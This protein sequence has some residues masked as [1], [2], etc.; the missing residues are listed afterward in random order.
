[1]TPSMT[2]WTIIA[3]GLVTGFA[4]IS[5][6]VLSDFSRH[7]LDLYCRRHDRRDRFH[8]VLDHHERVGLAASA[9]QTVAIVMLVLGVSQWCFPFGL[10]T[11]GGWFGWTALGVSLIMIL[12][13]LIVGLPWAVV[14]LWSAP[15]LYH[16]WALWKTIA[17]LLSPLTVAMGLVDTVMHRLAGQTDNDEDEEE[18]FE[19]EIRAIV[20]AGL[21]DGLLEAD[22]REMIEGVIELG[23]VDVAEIMT[24][25]S[26]INAL[27]VDIPW[28]D[29]LDLIVKFGRTRLPVY[30]G[31]LDQI[32]GILY[33]KDLLAEFSGNRT[34]PDRPLKKLL[35]P[36]WFVPSSKAVDEMLREFRRTRSHMAIVVDEYH[37]TSGV[38]TIEDALEEIVG[39]IADEMDSDDEIDLVR[40]DQ[41][42]LD[43]DGR[44]RIDELNEQFGC[45]LPGSDEYDTIAGLVVNLARRIPKPGETLQVMELRMTVLKASNRRVDRVRIERVQESTPE[46]TG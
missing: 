42:I 24:P 45:A 14:E 43:A 8:E 33:V 11:D 32:L 21:R 44:V 31:G 46:A 38:V 2:P 22:A 28:A 27:D 17:M 39:E 29:A 41:G 40:V 9:L 6:K 5:S 1:M 3:C 10:G 7:D 25:R 26:E 30:R 12:L 19:D 15:F 13:V 35:R 20:S 36:A 18:A 16:T 34:I 37:A 23:D 4:A